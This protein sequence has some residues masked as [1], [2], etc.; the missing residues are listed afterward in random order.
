MD[1]FRGT[2]SHQ[3]PLRGSLRHSQSQLFTAKQGTRIHYNTITARVWLLLRT[4]KLSTP[5]KMLLQLSK[6]ADTQCEAAS[7][8]RAMLLF[9]Q[10]PA[11]SNGR[12][13]CKPTTIQSAGMCTF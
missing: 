2:V 4:K 10:S 13:M 3:K 7:S 8:G 5:F 9:D 12:G 11:L 6:S 1:V